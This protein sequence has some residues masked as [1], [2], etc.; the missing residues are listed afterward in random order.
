VQ[1]QAAQGL[2]QG[3]ERVGVL[4]PLQQ[5]QA[6]GRGR[7]A[8]L[9]VQADEGQ[10]AEQVHEARKVHR[11]A[12]GALAQVGQDRLEAR[13]GAARVALGE[14]QGRLQQGDGGEGALAR[15]EP[16]QQRVGFGQ[17][18]LQDQVLQH[19]A[20]GAQPAAAAAFQPGPE[21]GV[22]LV[23][24]HLV[25]EQGPGRVA[26]LGRRQGLEPLRVEGL[27]ADEGQGVALA[28]GGA[29][30]VAQPVVG[31]EP[32]LGP[33]LQEGQAEAGQVPAQ[34]VQQQLAGVVAGLPGGGQGLELALAVGPA[35]HRLQ[36]GGSQGPE[37]V[38]DLPGQPGFAQ[39][40]QH[41]GHPRGVADPWRRLGRNLGPHQGLG[42]MA[43]RRGLPDGP[44]GHEEGFREGTELVELMIGD[45]KNR[46]LVRLS[47]PEG[48]RIGESA[49]SVPHFACTSPWSFACR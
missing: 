7:Q 38:V 4:A 24:H 21:G 36:G 10:E 14:V 49:R 18:P 19:G 27:A 40:L 1:Q 8:A 28:Q 5:L 31:G 42:Q 11:L 45:P 2:L 39:L 29:V 16:L 12:P 15:A 47:A 25:V 6:F 33:A 37:A 23:V 32:V 3:R 43:A 46:H 34:P 13:R 17:A 48:L 41:G 35:A 22:G 26:L 9:L 44:H 30:G 20:Q